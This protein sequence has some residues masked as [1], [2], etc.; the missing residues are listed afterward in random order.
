MRRMLHEARTLAEHY[1]DIVGEDLL[2]WPNSADDDVP[3]DPE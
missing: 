3:L 1:R 2:P